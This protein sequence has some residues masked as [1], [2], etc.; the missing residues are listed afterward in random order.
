MYSTGHRGRV[1]A[2]LIAV[3]PLSSYARGRA[4]LVV[5]ALFFV[6]SAMQAF[7]GVRGQRGQPPIAT[8]GRSRL[9]L[10]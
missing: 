6:D 3:P 1:A 2:G 7:A 9:P 4:Q 5:T 8:A 10:A